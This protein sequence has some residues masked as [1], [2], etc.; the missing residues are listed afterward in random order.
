M[1]NVGLEG[2]SLVGSFLAVLFAITLKVD[3]IVAGLALIPLGAGLSGFGYRLVFSTDSIGP[4][5]GFERLD[6]GSLSDIP[7]LGAVLAV[8]F[9]T[10]SYMFF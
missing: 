6:L 2:V 10:V 8:A 1:L 5:Q 4:V 9:P 3:Q 7:F